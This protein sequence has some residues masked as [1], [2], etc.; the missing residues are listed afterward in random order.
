MAKSTITSR[1]GDIEDLLDKGD[2]R[3]ARRLLKQIQK[4]EADKERE[5]FVEL[6]NRLRLDPQVFFFAV[7]LF[8]ALIAATIMTYANPS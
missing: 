3:S 7:A 8:L 1:L 2:N 5:K 6:H 4:P